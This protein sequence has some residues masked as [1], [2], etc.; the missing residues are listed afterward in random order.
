MG[1]EGMWAVPGV[2]SWAGCGVWERGREGP[3]KKTF[4]RGADPGRFIGAELGGGVCGR[5]L[6]MA[7]RV[8]GVVER[9]FRS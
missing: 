7:G 3:E 2:G 6:S 4:L 1:W 9:R 5:L 8:Y